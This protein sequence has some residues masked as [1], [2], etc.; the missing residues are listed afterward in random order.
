MYYLK[1]GMAFVTLNTTESLELVLCMV[2]KIS[3][4]VYL[5]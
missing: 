5:V 2:T 4:L 3:M 1:G